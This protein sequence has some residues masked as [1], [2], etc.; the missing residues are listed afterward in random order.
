MEITEKLIERFLN[1]YCT[2]AEA[3]AVGRFFRKNPEI[4]QKY[5]DRDWQEAGLESEGIEDNELMLQE[6]RRK[7]IDKQ[8]PQTPSIFVKM[9]LRTAGIAA[10]VL[11]IIGGYWFL[12]PAQNQVQKTAAG[13]QTLGNV[14]PLSSAEVRDWLINENSSEKKFTLKLPDG[15]VVTLLPKSCIRY[16]RT[17]NNNAEHTRDVYLNGEAFFDV[18]KDKSRPFS[19]FAGNMSTTALGTYFSVHE[20]ADGIMVKLYSGKV[21]IHSLNRKSDQED[22]FLKPGEQMKYNLTADLATVT[23]FEKILPA[24]KSIIEPVAVVSDDMNFNNS[25]LT[26]VLD[27]LEKHYHTRIFYD[28]TELSDMYFSGKVLESD[29]LTVILKVIGNMNGLQIKDTSDGYVAHKS[30]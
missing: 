26:D 19:V 12:Q 9:A 13:S 10:T 8:N 15:S 27:E 29:S 24:K 18:A 17:F 5:L 16:A 4:L 7:T 14:K 3:S 22:I 30:K 28:K 1:G 23:N 25:L 2:P 11:L 20:N 6:I 21:K